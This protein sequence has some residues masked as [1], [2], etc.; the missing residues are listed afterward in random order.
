MP[1]KKF[2]NSIKEAE[3]PFI[4]QIYKL[5]LLLFPRSRFLAK[6]RFASGEKFSQSSGRREA[7]V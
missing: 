3:D 5:P 1:P 6:L 2:P 7:P 4:S